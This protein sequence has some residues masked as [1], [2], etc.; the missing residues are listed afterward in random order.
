MYQ[1]FFQ[2]SFENF[3]TV[4]GFLLS[5]FCQ[6]GNF[7]LFQKLTSAIEDGHM[8]ENDDEKEE[9]SKASMNGFINSMSD[10]KRKKMMKLVGDVYLQRLVILN[11]NILTV[12]HFNFKIKDLP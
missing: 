5:P 9:D 6:V 2:N 1:L 4:E 11:I 3:T 7:L 8:D 10:K 12:Y